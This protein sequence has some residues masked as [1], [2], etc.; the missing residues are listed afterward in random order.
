MY[1]GVIVR[2][3]PQRGALLFQYMDIIYKAYSWYFG[4]G[5]LL[6]DEQFR[7]WA[8]TNSSLPWDLHSA[9]WL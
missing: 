6:Y 8:A 2:Q 4:S 1:A 9:L 5:W 7:M 3:Q